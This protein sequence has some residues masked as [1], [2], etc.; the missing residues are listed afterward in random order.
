MDSALLSLLS[1]LDAGNDLKRLPRTGWL[2]AGVRPAESVADHS[3]ATA[4]LALALAESINLNPA[5]HGLAAPLNI[6]RLLRLALLHDLAESQVTD[7]PKRATQRLS[8]AAK[9][10]AEAAA[11]EEIVAGAPFADAWRALHAEYAAA[12][13]AEARLVRDADKLEMVHQALRYRAQGSTTLAEFLQP[14]AFAF[15]LS[16]DFFAGLLARG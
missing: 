3:Y 11:F 12:E 5:A 4:L 16:A 10:A 6:E 9:L 13:S 14:P 2:L 7:L 1:L 15:A 8:R